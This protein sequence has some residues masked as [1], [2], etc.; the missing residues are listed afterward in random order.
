MNFL[1]LEYFVVVAEE[2][3]I[4]KASQRLFISQ[5]SLSKHIIKLEDE[6][7][8]QLFERQPA[9]ELTYA[10]SR[11]LKTASKILDL[12]RQAVME[13][14]DITHHIRGELKIGISHTR[15]RVLLPKVLPN[16]AQS[17]PSIDITIKEGNSKELEDLLLHGKIDLLVGFLP[18]ILDIAETIE[19]FEDRLLLVVP[20]KFMEKKYGDSTNEMIQQFKQGVSVEQFSDF[21]FLLVTPGNRVR[22]LFESYLKQ[23][24]LP[25]N[26][27]LE[28]ESIETLLSLSC[29]GM[30]IT[31]YPEMFVKNLSPMLK[32]NKTSHVHFFP[33]EDKNT[34]GR[35]AIAY[36]RER[37][38]SD[39]MKFFIEECKRK[40]Q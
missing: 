24:Q 23:K 18:V 39:P 31:I 2:L 36:H 27:I 14:D 35:L 16:F 11:F 37:Y 32:R 5:Q 26:V 4:T 1:S 40:F 21:P 7:N 29:E 33:L 25:L 13:M 34:V 12:K 30:G 19:I 9:F 38:F 15:G 3:N 22:T 17:Y 8:V 10:G 20:H 6:L 28:M